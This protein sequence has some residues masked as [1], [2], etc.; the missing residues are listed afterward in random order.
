MFLSV[1]KGDAIG[2]HPINT[3]TVNRLVA[4]YGHRAGLASL[5]GENRLSPHDLRRTAARNAYE[6]GCPLPMIQRLLGHSDVSTTMRDIGADDS[7]SGGAVDFALL[8][9]RAIARL[10]YAE[11]LQGGDGSDLMAST[12]SRAVTILVSSTCPN[13]SRSLSPATR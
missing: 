10:D 13:T 1:N 6:N 4:E 7:D 3:S 5:D 8:S 9:E 12:K 11:S 2:A